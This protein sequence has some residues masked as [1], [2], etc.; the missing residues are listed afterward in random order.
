MYSEQKNQ[1]AQYDQSQTA[2]LCVRR[3]PVGN[4]EALY[5]VHSKGEDGNAVRG[6]Y[7]G[8]ES[9]DNLIIS[10]RLVAIID[11]PDALLVCP[12]SESQRVGEIAGLL[13]GRG[14][15][16]AA[17]STQP[18]TAPGAHTPFSSGEI[19]SRSNG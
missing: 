17:S 11:S 2:E 19:P 10:D 7:L 12:R 16:N 18:F 13:K 3:L 15:T 1:E 6:E 4:F 8:I 9:N 14:E 5:S